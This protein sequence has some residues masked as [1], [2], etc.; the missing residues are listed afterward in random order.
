MMAGDKLKTAKYFRITKDVKTKEQAEEE[1]N[2]KVKESKRENKEFVKA[3][4]E[5]LDEMATQNKLSAAR[6]EDNL[7]KFGDKM[8]NSLEVITKILGVLMEDICREPDK[9]KNRTEETNNLSNY[10]GKE[11]D[12]FEDEVPEVT[13]ELLPPA[14]HELSTSAKEEEE[15]K[16]NRNKRKPRSKVQ[17]YTPSESIPNAQKPKEKED[18]QDNQSETQ[19]QTTSTLRELEEKIKS[20]E[21]KMRELEE[22]LRTM[23]LR[24]NR[25]EEQENGNRDNENE[26]PR[27]QFPKLKP[28][29][30]T[31]KPKLTPTTPIDMEGNEETETTRNEIQP[32]DWVKVKLPRRKYALRPSLTDTMNKRVTQEL[33]KHITER[34]KGENPPK[35]KSQ[36]EMHPDT[37]R[38]LIQGMLHKSGLY[39]GVGPL[40]KEHMD[41]VEKVLNKKGL[42]KDNETKIE[43]AQRT[44]KSLVRSWCNRNLQMDDK[45]WDSLEIENILMTVNSDI[46]F[47]QCKSQ[48]DATKLMSRAR[49]LPKDSGPDSP[50]LTMYVDSRAAKRHKA[51]LNIAKTI[52]ENLKNTIQTNVQTGKNNYLLRKREKGSE[53]PWQEIPPLKIIQELPDFEIGIFKDI[54]NGKEDEN[55]QEDEPQEEEEEEIE[56]MD[57]IVEDMI[58][59][60]E[61]KQKRNRTNES[62]DKDRETTMRSK[63]QNINQNQILTPDTS[64][65]EETD[66]TSDKNRTKRNLNSTPNNQNLETRTLENGTRPETKFIQHYFLM[67]EMPNIKLHSTRIEK[68]S[69]VLETPEHPINEEPIGEKPTRNI[70][71]VDQPAT[72]KEPFKKTVSMEELEKESDKKIISEMFSNQKKQTNY[73]G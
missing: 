46:I 70:R 22:R 54:I 50:Q 51:I 55:E 72:E 4:K 40:T 18:N 25:T 17:Y 16:E 13:E 38:K 56:D 39:V 2:K 33:E 5:V 37:R 45:D 24:T 1:M 52:R 30:K 35:V 63:R 3:S 65:T 12:M 64:D 9:R 27:D 67:P 60:E 57:V 62:H 48:E 42:F 20:Q 49:F 10:K 26:I 73:H 31:T 66:N 29:Q 15:S 47:I 36:K 28:P 32:I 8:T 19:I 14:D 6:M 59:Q 21:N 71:T 11:E 23:E 41:R 61:N 44:V 53:V 34:Y 69:T 7:N 58:R 43:R 68:I